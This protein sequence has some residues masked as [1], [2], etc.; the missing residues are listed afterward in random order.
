[1]G[2]TCNTHKSAENCIQTFS[3]RTSY[4]LNEP[5]DSIKKNGEFLE[6]LSVCQLLNE[7]SAPWS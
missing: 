4:N 5:S 6:S 2:W 3:Q 7:G 1:M